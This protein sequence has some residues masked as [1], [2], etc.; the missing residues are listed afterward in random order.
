MGNFEFPA[1]IKQIGSIGDGL[2]VY[3]EDYVYTYLQQHA[4]AGGYD[5]KLAYLAGRD[6]II[7]GQNVLFISGAMQAKHTVN[8]DGILHFTDESHAK[9]NEDIEDYFPGQEIVGWMQSQPGFGTVLN[10]SYAQIHMENFTL[11]YQVLFVIDPMEKTST[12]YIWDGEPME[13]VESTGYFIYYDKNKNMH[14]YMMDNKVLKLKLATHNYIPKD[15][16]E[17]D[18]VPISSPKADKYSPRQEKKQHVKTRPTVRKSYNEQGRV[19]NMLVTLS[20]VLFIVCFIMGAGLIKNDGRIA[21][22]EDQITTLAKAYTNVL[23]YVGGDKTEA[24]FAAGREDVTTPEPESASPKPTVIQENGNVVLVEANQSAEPSPAEATPSEVS[25][26]TAT[27]AIEP[28]TVVTPSPTAAPSP[29]PS[30]ETAQVYNTYTVQQ[31]DSLLSISQKF[32]GTTA[33]IEKIMEINEIDDPDKIFY[34]KV[35]LMP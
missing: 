1:N 25:A 27:Q 35:L 16:N 23:T 30:D 17:E 2:R 31:G 26:A 19:M 4:D 12:F 5:E 13:M 10:S 11:P 20:A 7:D 14:D 34:G 28:L 6:M 32:Y 18:R 3:M 33:M 21:N 22:L 29:E 24:V 8:Q 15:D 9:A